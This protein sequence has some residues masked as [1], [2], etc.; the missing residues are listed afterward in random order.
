MSIAHNFPHKSQSISP[1]LHY[2]NNSEGTRRNR[3]RKKMSSTFIYKFLLLLLIL[4]LPITIP[5][6]SPTPTPVVNDIS[7]ASRTE[8]VFVPYDKMTGPEF[9]MD[10]SILVPYAE[11]LKLKKAAELKPDK[12][13]FAPIASLVNAVYEG[14]VK[15]DIALINLTLT[16]DVLAPPDKRVEVDIPFNNAA[17][18][19][20]AL[21]G[22]DAYLAPREESIGLRII[23]YGEGRRV[24]KIGLAIP[25]KV[26]GLSRQIEFGI[27]RVAASS[28]VL[29]V[30]DDVVLEKVPNST[31]ASTEPKG[32]N[33]TEIHASPGDGSYVLLKYRPRIEK[34]GAAAQTRF[35]VLQNILYEVS[36]QSISA[37]VTMNVHLITGKLSS[38]EIKIPQ[39]AQLQSVSGTFVK[40]WTKP[41]SDGAFTISLVKELEEDFSIQLKAVIDTPDTES[42][43]DLY[44]F[45]SPGSVSE[46]G[47]LSIKPTSLLTI[48]TEDSSGLEAMAPDRSESL[49]T[50]KYRFEQPGWTLKISR[51][52]VPARIRSSS[53]IIYEVTD[54]LIRLHTRSSLTI[55]GR[56]LFSLVVQIPDGYTIREIGP[57]QIISGYRQ[58]AN[59]IEINFRNEQV[60]KF[61]LELDLQHTRTG[62]ETRITLEP[63]AIEGAEEDMGTILL[64]TPP[65]LRITEI[66][67]TG[68]EPIDVRSLENQI[69]RISS[70]DVEL[71]PILAYRYFTPDAR[72]V[73]AIERQRTRTT[74]QTLRLVNIMPS[75]MR[76]ENTLNYTVEFSAT[77]SFHVLLPSSLGEEVRFAGADIKETVRESS[78]DEL[79]TWTIKIQRRIIGP[80]RLVVLFDIPLPE[81]E[82]GQPTLVDVPKVQAAHVARETGFIGVSRGENLEVRVASSEGLEAR[83]VKELPPPLSNAFLG[84]RYFD[85]QNQMLTLELVRHE[86][87]SVLGALIRRTH[88]ETVLNDQLQAVHEVIFEVQ[89]NREQYLELKFPPQME[90]W[91]AF[92]R[93]VPVRPITRQSDGALLI[94][95]IKS[96]SRDQAFRVRLIINE[97]P[98]GKKL[99]TKGTLLFTPPQPLNLPI[100]RT[101]WRLYLPR[102]YKYIDFGGTMKLE[103]GGRPSWIEPAAEKLLNDI[104][105]K[106]AGG[107]AKPTRSPEVA[108]V[109]VSYDPSE[110]PE[111]KQARLQDSA[112]EIPIVREGVQF[113]FSKLSGIG[114]IQIKYWNNKTLLLLQIGVGLVIF[115]IVLIA[116]GMAKRPLI[117]GIATVAFFIAA[118]LTQGLSGR[119]FATGLSMSF[120]VLVISLIAYSIQHSRKL[121]TQQPEIARAVPETPQPKTHKSSSEEGSNTTE[122]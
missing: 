10:Q 34:T 110:T 14:E 104:P 65:A 5:G 67:S 109:N 103:E 91:S 95:L 62:Q 30:H 89:N 56:G 105:A 24:L 42:I 117:A 16:I 113:V 13:D 49:V 68:L 92:V 20:A 44:E 86:L 38:V 19:S 96:E 97:S 22:A 52:P 47:V 21:E 78:K 94:E 46:S 83:D 12:P 23:C 27:P 57:E 81:S 112:L 45:L 7:T 72:S 25:V 17:V 43:I 107:I 61:D 120:A 63:I 77:D 100:L 37:E 31:P 8:V 18:R 3:V 115:I 50:K 6:Q 114:T 101:T 28:L 116:A 85:S 90:I 98:K 2:I 99:G 111:E 29:L 122:S 93:G 51:V 60:N 41:D 1:F 58:D 40:D 11:F 70:L 64:A 121:M 119:L 9:G 79:T 4:Y 71:V 74:C 108:S 36:S 80:Y 73:A 82:P 48:W 54:Q 76:I 59:R 106:V 35:S 84:F 26:Y 53:N 75:L 87:E 33:E 39:D 55:G 88:I 102:G 32:K 15:D 66:Q 69:N 118:S